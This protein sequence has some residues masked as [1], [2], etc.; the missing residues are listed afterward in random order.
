VKSEGGG[1]RR[2]RKARLLQQSRIENN[3]TLVLGCGVCQELFHRALQLTGCLWTM[4]DSQGAL[5]QFRPGSSP[6]SQESLKLE[7]GA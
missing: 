6:I 2:S 4:R 5:Q 1:L 7:L 3:S